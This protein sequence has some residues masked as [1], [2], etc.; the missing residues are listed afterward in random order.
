MPHQYQTLIL[1]LILLAAWVAWW[2]WAVNWVR[3]WEWLGR[4]AWVAVVLLVFL[5]GLVWSRIGPR[6]LD[7]G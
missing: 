2:L 4:G 6:E 7:V 1:G 5:A 3:A